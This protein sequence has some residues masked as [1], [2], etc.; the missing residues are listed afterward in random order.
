[1]NFDKAVLQVSQ[2]D[3]ITHITLRVKELIPQDDAQYIIAL[4]ETCSNI[5]VNL[6]NDTRIMVKNGSIDPHFE[7]KRVIWPK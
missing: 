6:Y 4:D 2:I 3:G 1:M 5:H 7:K